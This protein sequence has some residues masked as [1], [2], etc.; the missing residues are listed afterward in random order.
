M[1]K[2]PA[3]N[4]GDPGDVL[5][6]SGYEGLN[7]AELHGHVVPRVITSL[8]SSWRTAIFANPLSVIIYVCVCVSTPWQNSH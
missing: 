4:R 1:A 3:A 5:E 2:V 7:M 6:K 8:C